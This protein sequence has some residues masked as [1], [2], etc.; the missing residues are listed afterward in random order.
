MKEA[1]T[2]VTSHVKQVQTNFTAQVKKTEVALT[3]V[4]SKNAWAEKTFTQQEKNMSTLANNM[5]T[6]S[7]ATARMESRTTRIET[8]MGEITH[9]LNFI[10]T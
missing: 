3:Q 8:H 7:H 1:V 10:S 4:E 6:L 9:V 5:S 2:E